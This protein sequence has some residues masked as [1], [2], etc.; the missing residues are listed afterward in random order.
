MSNSY[1][2]VAA[3]N[4][5]AARA[6]APTQGEPNQLFQIHVSPDGTQA[7]VQADWTDDAAMALL[8][9]YLGDLQENGSAS[10]GVYDE[11]AKPEW[12]PSEE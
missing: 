8:G 3:E 1:Y 2:L 7:I 4:I 9:T 5:E 12:Q 6:L 11:T 10:Q